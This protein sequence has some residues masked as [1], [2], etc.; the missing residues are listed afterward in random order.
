MVMTLLMAAAAI[1]GANQGDMALHPEHISVALPRAPRLE[2]NESTG[3]VGVS[4][5]LN[6]RL[7]SSS[8]SYLLRVLH[9]SFAAGS[10]VALHHNFTKKT[11]ERDGV[12]RL[13]CVPD[14]ALLASRRDA[15]VCF[16][17][18]GG[19]PLRVEQD[20]CYSS[21]RSTAI[22][23]QCCGRRLL[24]QLCPGAPP[25]CTAAVLACRCHQYTA[26]M[27]HASCV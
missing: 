22:T 12:L 1:G 6:E 14:H 27:I 10:K 21:P 23:Q 25:Q 9:T 7:L 2:I 18:S 11:Y 16:S 26:Q 24:L 4:V 8:S 3:A 20:L 19:L 5:Q 13:M 17:L 15:L